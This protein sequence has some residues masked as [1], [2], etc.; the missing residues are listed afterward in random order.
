MM[1]RVIVFT[2]AKVGQKSFFECVLLDA[3][4]PDQFMSDFNWV[5]SNASLRLF[6]ST[7]N[8]RPKGRSNG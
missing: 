8:L 5:K 7:G 6:A 2:S 3:L 1:Y 4:F